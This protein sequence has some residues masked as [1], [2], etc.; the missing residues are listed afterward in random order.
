MKLLKKALISSAVLAGLASTNVFAGTEAC[1]EIYKGDVVVDH[2]V[3]FAA[4]QCYTGDVRDAN[5]EALDE[6]SVAYE[7]TKGG[8][9]GYAI[10][11]G[12]AAFEVPPTTG[13]AGNNG[14]QIVYIPTTDLPGASRVKVKL[15]NAVFFG[16][17]NQIFLLGSG[18][19]VLATS[20][21]VVDG[22]GE[23]EFLTQSGITIPAGTRMAFSKGNTLAT[24]EP[25]GIRTQNT[26]CTDSTSSAVI[27][28]AA[29]SARTDGGSSIIGGVSRAETLIDI[30]PQYVTF[31]G[32]ATDA[33]VNAQ[34]TNSADAEIVARTEFVFEANSLTL[35]RTDIIAPF[36]F[37][38]RE[39]ALDLAHTLTAD[40]E[41]ELMFTTTGDTG[42]SVAFGIFNTQTAA[43]G[44]LGGQ[45]TLD[46]DDD[47]GYADTAYALPAPAVF[48]PVATGAEPAAAASYGLGATSNS[49]FFTVTQTD[50]TVPMGFNYAVNVKSTLNFDPAT[51]LDHCQQTTNTHNIGINGAVLKVPYAVAAEGNFVRVT[52]EHTQSAEVTVDVFSESADGTTG[53]RFAT[54]VTL[55]TVPAKSSVVYFVQDVI[56]AAVDQKGYTGADGGF[57]T[58]S[59]GSN[60]QAGLLRHTLTFAVTSPRDTVHGVTVQKIPG[61]VDRVMPVLD[62]NNWNQ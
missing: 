14:L 17:A 57:A 52:N 48:T 55:G 15:T 60:A 50:D 58:G 6:G 8:T 43:P 16:N 13:T 34:S 18:D 21:G 47:Y 7:L 19:N 35:Q 32:T 5:L 11:L 31:L 24:L 54:A 29:T 10:E 27:S 51:L 23:I 46:A 45:V 38:D 44:V 53:N 33:E 61:G 36:A 40:D 39:A 25:V 30:S 3:Q 56:D 2:G 49:H 62:Q 42:S 20:D 12:Q 59:Y 9:S 28:I 4:A 37:V 26:T 41:L 1:F 22:Q